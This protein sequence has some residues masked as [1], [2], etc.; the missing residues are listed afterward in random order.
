MITELQK[1][2]IEDEQAGGKKKTS[3]WPSETEAMVFDIYHKWVGTTPTN[4]IQ[5]ETSVIFATGK[6]LEEA[7][8]KK[9]VDAGLAQD[10][11][12]Q[13][14]IEIER[15]GV[16][17]SGYIDAL[18][19]SGD[20]IELKSYYGYYQQKD[21]ESGQPRT[22]YLKQLAIYMDA[23][24]K[25]KGTL[26]YV[27][28]DMG[29]MYEFELVREEH[30]FKC[31][32]ICFCLSETYERW[33][34]LYKNNVLKGIEPAPDHRYKIPV[35]EVDWTSLSNS[36]ITKART[37]KKVIGDHPWIVQY[38]AYKDLIIQRQ[39]VEAG[40]T[41]DELKYINEVTKGYSKK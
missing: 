19:K 13:V 21:L 2:L 33:A 9:M 29:K 22:S 35:E 28:R 40:Y 24:G 15:L 36:D 5:P 38:S 23:L 39:G 16:P 32:D 17:I 4:P 26:L 27:G 7:M 20:P 30:Q 8:V 25:D 6:A 10:L 31:N 14:H 12:E 34:R 11:E 3:M 41:S 1:F 37:N 18:D